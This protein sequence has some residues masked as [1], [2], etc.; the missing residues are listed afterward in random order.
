ML[1]LRILPTFLKQYGAQR[2]GTNYL[3]IL[4]QKNYSDV[5]VLMHVLGDK[6]SPP[7]P[8]EDLW[9]DVETEPDPALAFVSRATF[10]HPSLST[11][12]SD[13]RQHDT[14][15]QIAERRSSPTFLS[16]SS[17]AGAHL[18]GLGLH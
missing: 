6:H 12:E 11:A 16:W 5:C 1:G 15:R 10:R 14:V 9:A 2:T 17:G 18:H 8:F 4:L 13:P 7:A 3:R